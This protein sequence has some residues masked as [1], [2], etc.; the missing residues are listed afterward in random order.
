MN[1]I[2]K[3]LIY[4]HFYYRPVIYK[5]RK[6]FL[7][8]SITLAVHCG[9]KAQFDRSIDV[10]VTA[11]QRGLSGRI[12]MYIHKIYCFIVKSRYCCGLCL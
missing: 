7:I 9:F 2:A 6:L 5:I 3:T 1:Y 12:S 8:I 11:G 10:S 4:F